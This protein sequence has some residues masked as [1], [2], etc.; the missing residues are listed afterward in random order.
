M[1]FLFPFVHLGCWY[2]VYKTDKLKIVRATNMKMFTKLLFSLLGL[3]EVLCVYTNTGAKSCSSFSY[4]KFVAYAKRNVV[5]YICRGTRH[6]RIKNKVLVPRLKR[7]PEY[8]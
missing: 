2:K 5:H 1:F 4:L 7:I 8:N 6:V 3:I